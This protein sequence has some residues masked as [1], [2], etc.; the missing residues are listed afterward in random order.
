M[1]VRVHLE[2]GEHALALLVESHGH[3]HLVLRREA[4]RVP[5]GQFWS[6]KGRNTLEEE[7]GGGV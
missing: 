3:E 1:V 2:F 5:I 6:Q 7:G 4:G